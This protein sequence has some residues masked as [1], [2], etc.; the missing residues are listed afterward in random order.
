M[1]AP[2]FREKRSSFGGDQISVE[3]RPCATVAVFRGT[4]KDLSAPNGCN[5]FLQMC[6]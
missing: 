3:D 2:F 1:Q 5:N 6:R 4:S